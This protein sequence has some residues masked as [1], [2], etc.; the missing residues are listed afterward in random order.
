MGKSHRQHF[1]EHLKKTAEHHLAM[2][3]ACADAADAHTALG[4]THG[5]GAIGDEHRALAK[6][7]QA[8][9]KAHAAHAGHCVAQ[10]E[11]LGKMTDQEFSKA[12]EMRSPDGVY[13]RA[14]PDGVRGTIPSDNPTVDV[15]LIGRPGGPDGSQDPKVPEQHRHLLQ[16]AAAPD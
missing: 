9:G 1:I 7:H 15:K 16:R 12:A 3:T 8:M 4:D 10:G 11:E 6:C 2:G 14:K 5:E 13:V